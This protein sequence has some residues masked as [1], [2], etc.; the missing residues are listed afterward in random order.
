[1]SLADL[2]GSGTL[3]LAVTEHDGKAVRVLFTGPQLPT[4][5]SYVTGDK[6]GVVVATDLD[7]DGRPDLAIG[8]DDGT[9]SVVR[10]S[11]LP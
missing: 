7:G 9:L 8:V 2:D 1:V 10:N 4:A 6:P 11:C 5:I 3:D